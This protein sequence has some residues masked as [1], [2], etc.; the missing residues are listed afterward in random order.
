[1]IGGQ[2]EVR[3]E[4]GAQYALTD[5]CDREFEGKVLTTDKQSAIGC[6]KA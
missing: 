1:M 2:V 4:I 6:A 5:G 3:Q